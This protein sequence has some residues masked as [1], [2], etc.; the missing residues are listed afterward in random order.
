MK[1]LLTFSGYLVF[2]LIV[3]FFV[4]LI[5][6]VVTTQ[7]AEISTTFTQSYFQDK[8]LEPARGVILE[9]KKKDLE[10]YLSLSY[11]EMGLMLGGQEGADIS[12]IGIGVGFQYPYEFFTFSLGASYYLPEVYSNGNFRESL[13]LK[14]NHIYPEGVHCWYADDI[15]SYEL[16]GNIGAWFKVNVSCPVS[17]RVSFQFG[18]GYRYLNLKEHYVRDHQKYCPGSWVEFYEN[19]D[20]SG[21]FGFVGLTWS[22]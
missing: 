17:E 8:E 4:F 10:V 7:G 12:L 15:Y 9:V 22:F 14:I 20:L 5:V 13:W 18:V 21:G 16:H 19:R 2:W 6:R 11:E 1:H 3:F